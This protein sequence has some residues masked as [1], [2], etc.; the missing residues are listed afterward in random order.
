MFLFAQVSQA[1]DGRGVKLFLPENLDVKGIQIPITPQIES[2][3]RYIQ[4]ETKIKF[5]I[6]YLPWKRAQIEVKQGNGILYG[7]SKSTE[8]LESYRFS[9]PV[10]T[11]NIWAISYGP[12]SGNLAELNDLK[13]KIVIS[14]LGI[15]HGIE[16]ER[17][18]NQLF[19]VQEDF[20]T[21]QERFKKLIAQKNSV[22]LIPVRQELSR[23]QA[24]EVLHRQTITEFNDPDF[25]GRKFNISQNPMFYDTIHFASSKNHF[26]DVM[27][28]IDLAIQRGMKNGSLPKVLRE[29]R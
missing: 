12:N 18:R 21:I 2:V 8:R 19:V 22:M 1:N 10:I 7:F 15:S 24:E 11:L 13:G 25:S 4:R 20:L 14:S 9:V 6:V 23:E 17:A 3:L 16:F 28:K 5:S 27:N 26:Q 29:Y